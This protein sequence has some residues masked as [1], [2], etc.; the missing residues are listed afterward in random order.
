[1]LIVIVFLDVRIWVV[2]LSNGHV[3]F[4]FCLFV[5]YATEKADWYISLPLMFCV[6]CRVRIRRLTE[7][8]C[9]AVLFNLM[10]PSVRPFRVKAGSAAIAFIQNIRDV[11][12]RIVV[13]VC[14]R[15]CWLLIWH[16]ETKCWTWF[17]SARRRPAS[18]KYVLCST[19][20]FCWGHSRRL[21]WKFFY[22]LTCRTS[23]FTQLLQT[24][25]GIVIH[26]GTRPLSSTS[27]TVYGVVSFSAVVSNLSYWESVRMFCS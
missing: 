7:Q 5:Y 8:H 10:S 9:A 15:W 1:M 13:L 6:V 21:I 20:K 24:F 25:V 22:T 12:P 23:G 2:V 18:E 4:R 3:N 19:S 14:C 16:K 11:G 26:T 17:L 27:V